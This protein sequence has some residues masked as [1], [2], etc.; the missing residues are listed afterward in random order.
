MSLVMPWVGEPLRGWLQRHELSLW[1]GRGAAHSVPHCGELR[2]ATTSLRTTRV[3]VAHY[4]PAA[5]PS[6]WTGEFDMLL[7]LAQLA[8]TRGELDAGGMVRFDDAYA[9]HLALVSAH[10]ATRGDPASDFGPLAQLAPA[11]ERDAR[12]VLDAAAVLRGDAMLRCEDLHAPSLD[13]EPDPT[14]A[15]DLRSATEQHADDDTWSLIVAPFWDPPPLGSDAASSAQLLTPWP[16]VLSANGRYAAAL[17][18]TAPHCV[19]RHLERTALAGDLLSVD[20]GAVPRTTAGCQIVARLWSDNSHRSASRGALAHLERAAA[21][22]A[23][24]ETSPPDGT[25]QAAR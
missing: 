3:T 22:A 23:A 14:R 11:V 6:C 19:A 25:P 17:V 8:A 12:V 16:H 10:Y 13:V 2:S 24:L 21:A 15:G 1:V 5:C 20:G 4:L 18:A 7:H 9:A